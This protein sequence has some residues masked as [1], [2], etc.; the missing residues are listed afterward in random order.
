[1]LQENWVTAGVIHKRTESANKSGKSIAYIQITDLRDNYI[2]IFLHGESGQYARLND[3]MVIYV[4][5]ADILS[6]KDHN[7]KIA[8]SVPSS[9]HICCLGKAMDYGICSSLQR[10]GRKCT[11]A[12][13]L[14]VSRYCMYHIRQTQEAI[15]SLHADISSCKCNSL[16]S[17]HLLLTPL[18]IVRSS[19][20]NIP[21]E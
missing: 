19:Y 6:S 16:F 13:N 17:N 3:G 14:E 4:I 18:L 8:L 10:N 9:N 11:N 5:N 12:V 2:T 15:G 20:A 7:Q 1:M 21:I